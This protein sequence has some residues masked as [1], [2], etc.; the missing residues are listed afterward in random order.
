MSTLVGY[1]AALAARETPA[2][3]GCLHYPFA[4]FE[5]I[6]PTVVTEAA[7]LLDDPPASMDVRAESR[8]LQPGSYD[9][10][11]ELSVLVYAPTGVGCSLSYSRFD[12]DGRRVARC[13]GIYGITNNDGRWG[14]ELVSTI[15]TPAEAIG[16][17]YADAEQAALR[18]NRDWM[19]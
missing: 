1:F 18:R 4:T 12:R 16:V 14:V 2:L 6:E 11:D 7:Q 17:R 5:G 13:D 3:A 19:L 10:L 9:L 8:F 15:V